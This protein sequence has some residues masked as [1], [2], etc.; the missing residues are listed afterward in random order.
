MIFQGVVDWKGKFVDA[1]VGF[2]GSAHDS[3]VLCNNDL[4][5]EAERGNTLQAP[6]VNIGDHDTHPYLKEDIAYPLAAWLMKPFLGGTCD[7]DE[8]MFNRELSRAR[9]TVEHAFS[10]LEGGWRILQKRL[11]NSL[12]FAIKSTVACI[13]LH[14]FCLE[15]NDDR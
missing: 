12:P 6:Q 7:P 8:I 2:P 9:V 3:R 4:Y 15:A 14:T 1:V 13:V 10:I 5:H 11:D